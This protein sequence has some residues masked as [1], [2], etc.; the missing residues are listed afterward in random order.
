LN[1]ASALIKQILELQDFETWAAV[2]QD[3]LPSE[4]HKLFTIINNHC[5][6]YH[7][8]PSFEDLKLE[9]RD[10]STKEKLYAIETVEI[11]VEADQLL[12]YLKNEY[13][14]KEILVELEDY[15]DN[16]VAFE[17]AEESLAHLYQ[18]AVDVEDKIDLED[19]QE[20]M[21]R[22]NLF[23][24]EEEYGKYLTLGLNDDFDQLHQFGPRDLILFG[25]WRGSGK[26]VICGN[27]AV[28]KYNEGRSTITYS[29]EMDKKAILRRMCSIATGVDANRLKM[30]NLN[31]TEWEKVATWWAGRFENCDT[32]L[33]QYLTH[34][35]F[36]K[37]HIALTSKCELRH[38]CQLDVVYDPMLT[39]GKID[40]DLDKKMKS[41]LDISV[42]IVDYLNKVKLNATP[43]KRGAFDWIEQLEVATALKGI[44]ARF[45]RP[46]IAPFQT[47]EDGGVSFS[48]GILIDADAAY[49]LKAHKGDD[50]CMA[51]EC[52]KMRD[53]DEISFT[54]RMAWNCLQIGPESTLHPDDK[55]D[56]E[57]LKTGETPDDNPPF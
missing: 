21:Q 50:P 40:A 19:A 23:E 10:V 14:Q 31:V 30:R 3:Y 6:E 47:K 42:I 41:G 16:S 48:K 11:D 24:S 29:T 53:G 5:S 25:G 20:T 45:E 36:D 27:V 51:F 15:V 49:T 17:T 9:I 37:F 1:L 12:D 44:A 8:L 43:S 33:K 34:R 13:A 22:I 46:V 7:E 28:N 32:V 57:D 38:D 18:I 26:T 39:I 54:S 55:V 2:R 52:I 35:D 56:V 4:Y